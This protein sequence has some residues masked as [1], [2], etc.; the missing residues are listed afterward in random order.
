MAMYGN[1]DADADTVIVKGSFRSKFYSTLQDV[2][3]SE[4]KW[5]GWKFE[6][7]DLSV[8]L[9]GGRE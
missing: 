6:M 2:R 1:A 4:M 7:G 3:S 5:R 8:C 9:V